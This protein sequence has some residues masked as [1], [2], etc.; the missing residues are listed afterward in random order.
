MRIPVKR[1][2]ARDVVNTKFA[3]CTTKVFVSSEA[4]ETGRKERKRKKEM[5][6]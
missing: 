4:G 1:D 2:V 5:V 3:R 6:L